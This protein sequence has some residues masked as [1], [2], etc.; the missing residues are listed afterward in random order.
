MIETAVISALV[1]LIVSKVI[2]AYH[3]KKIDSFAKETIEMIKKYVELFNEKQ[4]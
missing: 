2:A 3:F 4:P 1:S